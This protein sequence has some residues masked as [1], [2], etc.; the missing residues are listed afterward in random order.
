[1]LILFFYTLISISSSSH[2]ISCPGWTLNR[3]KEVKKFLKQPG[4]ID[5]Y[6]GVTIKWQ[7]GHNPDLVLVHPDGSRE[8]IDLKN[9][10][11]NQ[12]DLHK[13][14][15]NY[16]SKI[17]A[18]AN[19]DNGKVISPMDKPVKLPHDPKSKSDRRSRFPDKDSPIQ[20]LSRKQRDILS[21]GGAVQLQTNWLQDYFLHLIALFVVVGM[22]YTKRH[23]F[24]SK[25][26]R[27]G[28]K[29][30]PEA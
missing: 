27:M 5:Q 8:T 19:N 18:P 10:N 20:R 26:M 6:T 17:G 29:K 15:S 12:K 1:M 25:F 2:V 9:Y 4:G 16:F 3:L 11:T 21:G 28:S 13:L 14:F 23:T 22:L 24:L 30:D 7:K